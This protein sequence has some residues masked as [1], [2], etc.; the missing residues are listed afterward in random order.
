MDRP[1][2]TLTGRPARPAIG[3]RRAR[4][5]QR[6]TALAIQRH[7]G[8]RSRPGWRDITRRAS[9]GRISRPCTPPT[10]TDQSHPGTAHREAYTFFDEVAR[11]LGDRLDESRFDPDRGLGVTI[12][13]LDGNDTAAIND[14]PTS[15]GVAD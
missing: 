12:F 1:D 3:T 9:F 11:L 13:D 2:G 6:V 4:N 5:D 7:A 15:L 8:L 10:T 14:I